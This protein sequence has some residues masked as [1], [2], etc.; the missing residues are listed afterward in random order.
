M[1]FQ[2]KDE[3]IEYRNDV[4]NITTQRVLELLKCLRIKTLNEHS[5]ERNVTAKRSKT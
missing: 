3:L 1:T 5:E 2:N 4:N